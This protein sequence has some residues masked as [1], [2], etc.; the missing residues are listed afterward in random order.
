MISFFWLILT[1]EPWEIRKFQKTIHESQMSISS[2]ESLMGDISKSILETNRP[3]KATPT[4]KQPLKQ[5]N[6][7]VKPIQQQSS[8]VKN[9]QILK[10]KQEEAAIIKAMKSSSMSPKPNASTVGRY[11][12]FF[13]EST[14]RLHNKAMLKADTDTPIGQVT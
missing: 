5:Q 13:S 14:C 2:T 1:G 3:S 12:K 6:E 4:K 9:I 10:Q 11:V 7:T 8:G